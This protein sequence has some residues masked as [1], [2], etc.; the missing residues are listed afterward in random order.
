M[1]VSFTFWDVIP[2]LGAVQGLF[3]GSLFLFTKR[4]NVLANR[5]LGVLLLVFSIRLL[6]IVMFWTKFIIAFPHFSLIGFPLSYLIGALLYFFVKY[7]L[8]G[9]Q[10]LNWS[11]WLHLI[12]FLFVLLYMMPYYVLNAEIKSWIIEGFYKMD[13]AIGSS[14]IPAV[15]MAITLLQFPH[16][17]LYTFL[18]MRLL[19]KFTQDRYQ[20]ERTSKQNQLKWLK[21]LVIGFG[22]LFSSW[23]LYNILIIFG[24][25]YQMEIDRIITIAMT[26][27]IYAIGYFSFMY[28]DIY[29]ELIPRYTVKYETS[30]LSEEIVEDTLNK[31]EA[32]MTHEKLYRNNRLRLAD[33]ARAL[34]ISAHQLSQIINERL[35]RNF[36]DLVNGYRIEEA[37]KI[38]SDPENRKLTLLGVAYEVGFNNKT[39]FNNY[40]KRYTGLTPSQF[41]KQTSEASQKVE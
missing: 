26:V 32:A 8:S 17:L 1:E 23:L 15:R 5:L 30:T 39:S 7:M 36:F 13:P 16:V 18:S 29:M 31:L 4:G 21:R 37:K 6:G 10:K 27:F 14:N 3:V 12:P 28:P 35:N 22:I 11:F 25:A 34:D 24:T 2:L 38:L 19:N 20:S 40:F 9:E 33:L 41:V